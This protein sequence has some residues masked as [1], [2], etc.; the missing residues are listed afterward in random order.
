MGHEND[1][2]RQPMSDVHY[3]L[4]RL[5]EARPELS[6]RDIARELG[7]SLGKA[8]YCLQALIRRGLVKVGNF[9]NSHNK[10]AYMY[11]LTPRGIERK[12]TLAVRFLK[13]KMREYEALRVEIEQMRR[14]AG[15]RGDA[16]AEHSP[17]AHPRAPNEPTS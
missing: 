10:A 12:A 3:K 8:N 6:Q 15:L 4:M 9:T 11:L 16:G 14:E 2:D 13:E 7:I 17:A 1:S 5:L